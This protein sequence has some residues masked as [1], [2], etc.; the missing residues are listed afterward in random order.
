MEKSY[1]NVI[2]PIIVEYNKSYADSVAT[3]EFYF[4]DTSKNANKNRFMKRE[5]THGQNAAGG[6][7]EAGY[8]FR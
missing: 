5:V 4:L 8:M 2:T 1:I 7:D 3:N 6:A